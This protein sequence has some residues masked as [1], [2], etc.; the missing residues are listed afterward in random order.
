MP[1]VIVIGAGV[2]GIT[3]AGY[4]ARQGYEVTVVEKCDQPGGRCGQFER[5]GHRFDTG[6]TMYL[7]PD[8]YSQAF[9]ALD[10]RVEDHLDLIR[11]DP[12]Y[13]VHFDDGS[14]LNLT[15][16]MDSMR[17]Q[18]EGIEPGSFDNYLRYL[19]EGK[20]NYELSIPNFAQRDFRSAAEFFNLK[21]MM[22]VLKVKA[23]KH[24]YSNVSGYFKNPKL[25]QAF[26]FQDMYVGLSPYKAPAMFSFLQYTEMV[27]GVWF[28]KG[29]MYS[30]IEA[31]VRIASRWGVEFMFDNAV[32]G[33]N[34][35][36]NR[37]KSVTLSD[38][39]EI[40]ADIVIANADLPYVYETL[41]SD[42]KA[43]NQL[44]RK[45]YSCS[46]LMFFW[47]V[48]KQFLQLKTNNL[49]FGG[50][51]Q[52]SFD[53][54][55][56]DHALPESPSFYLHAPVRADASMAPVGQDSLTV[57]I[58]VGHIDESTPQDWKSVRARARDFLLR[59]LAGIGIDDLEEHIKFETVYT[60]LEWKRRY[61]LVNGSTHGL[62]H[63]LLQMGYFR[64]RNRHKTIHNL[65]FVG[66]ST[67]PGT[68]LPTVLMS[69]QLTAERIFDE[70]GVPSP[71]HVGSE[72]VNYK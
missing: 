57:V 32:S 29:G 1:S 17:D 37:A 38:G 51:Y 70:V 20:R 63:S 19:R 47:G 60:P 3:T 8:F 68:G 52:Q 44:G 54:I 50:N 41:L 15:S 55:V 56:E 43:S 4:L 40:T 28:P 27:E 67:H 45:E 33:V 26:T 62:S 14:I 12:S 66:A 13:C 16:D 30:I 36:N 65:Y 21:N 5:D 11:I 6:P 24:H 46:T 48:R 22:I 59:R 72:V 64:P 58:P 53:C 18:L 35:E 23:L 61:N 49:F 31:L 7:M 71:V 34:V 25:R 69:A 10:E 42:G 9:A 39:R 2:G